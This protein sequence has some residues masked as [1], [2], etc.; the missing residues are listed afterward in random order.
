MTVAPEVEG[1]LDMLDELR[2]ECVMAIGHSDADYETARESI[3]R[4]VCSCNAHLQRHESF[5]PAPPGGHGR[6][7][8]ERRLLRGHL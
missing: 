2:G 8:G 4:G 5:P 7:A 6:R 1:V 3:R